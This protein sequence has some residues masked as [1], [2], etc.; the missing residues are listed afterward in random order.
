MCGILRRYV[1]N[2]IINIRRNLSLIN[3]KNKPHRNWV[4]I[5]LLFV[6][7]LLLF[8]GKWL[9]NKYDDVS[10]DQFIYQLKTSAAGAHSELVNSVIVQVF[11]F[12]I[13]MTALEILLYLLCSGYFMDRWKQNRYYVQFCAARLC[14]FIT[15]RALPL[16]IVLLILSLTFFAVK[17]DVVAY[18]VVTTTESDFIE[19]HYVNPNEVDLTFPQ[20]KRNLVYI[21]LESMEVTFSDPAAGETI[22]ENYIPELTALAKE[23]INFSNTTGIGGALNFE[24]TTWT[25]AAMVAQTSGMV[26]QVPLMADSYGGENKYMPGLV[27]I[28]EVLEK[29]GY[30]Q[31]L[32]QGSDAEFAGCA[33]YFSEHGGFEII[34]INTLK[35][36]NRLP[37]DYRVW[38][39]FED[40]KLFSFAREELTRLSESGEPFNFTM[41]T[42]DTHCPDGYL[43]DACGDEYEEQY[44]N[45]L[46]CSSRQVYELVSWIRE[47]PFYANTTIIISGDHMTMDPNFLKDVDEN[48]VRTIYNCIINSPVTPV[49]EKNR[50]FG[51]FDLFPTTLAAMGVQIEGERLGL[52]TNLFSDKQTLTEEFGYEVLD[53]ELQK[54]SEFY[55]STFLQ[56]EDKE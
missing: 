17:L 13:I 12:A 31:T 53:L 4:L 20:N 32:L 48:Y 14:R 1:Y 54:S 16:V 26:V 36:Q 43:C 45:V 52:G 10:L 29:E 37:E 38:W 8:L 39:G 11:L 51:T 28:G 23:N 35:E 25:A 56:M 46:R 15:K 22:H 44:S 30:H 5:L 21:F 49:S 7:N 50:Q 3:P 24:G 42:T 18:M 6:S 19:N 9:G 34:D 47:Q 27:S 2:I 41:F 40:Q 55:N 33:S